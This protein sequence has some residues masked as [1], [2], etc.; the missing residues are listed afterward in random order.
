MRETDD[1]EDRAESGERAIPV[2]GMRGVS[3]VPWDAFAQIR[4]APAIPSR[5]SST[6]F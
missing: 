6:A 2:L 3:G 5:I 1:A 4:A